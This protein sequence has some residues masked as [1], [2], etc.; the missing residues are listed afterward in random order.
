M[1]FSVYCTFDGKAAEALAFYED[2]FGIE[3]IR[4]QTYGDIP[5]TDE[6]SLPEEAKHRILYAEIPFPNLRMM[7][8]DNLPSVEPVVGNQLS[9]VFE[10]EL[11]SEVSRVFDRLKEDGVVEMELSDT[12]YS[13]L[14]GQVTDRF[15]ISWTISFTGPSL[16]DY[17]L[18]EEEE[19][20]LKASNHS[21]EES[22]REEKMRENE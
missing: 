15:G 22:K 20:W 14:A 3:P 4:V 6:F 5:P 1:K 9:M 8:S 16:S 19:S 10:S 11:R 12:F 21:S 13:P 18:L 17:A 2:V 7:I